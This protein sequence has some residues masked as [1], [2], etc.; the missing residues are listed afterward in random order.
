MRKI[1]I[2]LCMTFM[3]LLM[4]L[5]G[6]IFGT[7][8]AVD[9]TS[10]RLNS[11]TAE[12]AN[13]LYDEY[14]DIHNFSTSLLDVDGVRLYTE[15]SN[16]LG[17][18]RRPNAF[19]ESTNSIGFIGDLFG[20]K[21]GVYYEQTRAQDASNSEEESVIK[22]AD[23][24][25]TK[26]LTKT[27]E[28]NKENY[29]VSSILLAKSLSEITDLGIKLGAQLEDNSYNYSEDITTSN[30]QSDDKTLDTLEHDEVD[31]NNI[32]LLGVDLRT[33]IG[34]GVL[35]YGL[36]VS[37]IIR[38][39]ELLINNDPGTGW[40]FKTETSA[41]FM[42]P[43][44]MFK[45]KYEVPVLLFGKSAVIRTGGNLQRL[46]V[47][48]DETQ[49]TTVVSETILEDVQFEACYTETT[50][51]K[52]NRSE[53][54]TGYQF[55]IG[56][57]TQVNRHTVLGFG[58]KL[59]TLTREIVRTVKEQETEISQVIKNAG[60]VDKNNSYL[61]TA[62]VTPKE[63][64]TDAA[65][66]LSLVIPFGLETKLT[67]SFT[68]RLGAASTFYNKTIS[69]TVTETGETVTERVRKYD[70]G[71]EQIMEEKT[72]VQQA[73]DVDETVHIRNTTEL[74]FGFGY[75]IN[76]NISLDF[77]TAGDFTNLNNLRLSLNVKF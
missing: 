42:S 64:V 16:I 8:L 15:Q 63:I 11:M 50:N 45:A 70:N 34:S 26:S 77:R 72:G 23:E 51:S 74:N 36:E 73:I 60:E 18:D 20:F 58:I 44:L 65:A 40:S 57:E 28:T 3:T 39:V 21:L 38:Q 22:E 61:E 10:M 49:T 9:Q 35:S 25:V 19:N 31:K 17:G 56:S 4:V 24:S 7:A 6:T 48:Y 12:L 67:D 14:T 32:L 59:N 37:P 46:S 33:G 76:E 1:S 43:A 53:R 30:S 52:E 75:E 27:N 68:L 13:I 62:V 41:S 5:I 2:T 69:R 29:T 54:E 47:N 55:Y 71:D 66:N